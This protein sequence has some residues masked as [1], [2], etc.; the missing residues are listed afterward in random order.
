VCHLQRWHEKIVLQGDIANVKNSFEGTRR[1]V[2]NLLNAISDLSEGDLLAVLELDSIVPLRE[3]GE[4]DT[5][6]LGQDGEFIHTPGW[7]PPPRSL[8]HRA[9]TGQDLSRILEHQLLSVLVF[10]E[11]MVPSHMK[12]RR[13]KNEIGGRMW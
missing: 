13:A 2:V 9:Q 5:F 8:M 11:G 4:N 1:R 6:S 10:G 12:A 3:F 7:P